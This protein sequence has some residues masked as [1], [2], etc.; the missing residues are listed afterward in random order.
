MVHEREQFK[1]I[2]KLER[3]EDGGLRAWSPDVPGLVLSNADPMKVAQALGPAL[4]AILQEQLG[5]EVEVSRLERY[6][7]QAVS[8]PRQRARVP[9]TTT[10]FARQRQLEYAAACG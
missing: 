1:V 5:C 4:A 7:P 2:V 8:T 9:A 6:R 3:R 10:V